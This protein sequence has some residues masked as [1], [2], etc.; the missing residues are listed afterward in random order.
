MSALPKQLR[1]EFRETFFFVA[2]EHG[3]DA[4]IE[5]VARLGEQ[6]GSGD[7][8]ASELSQLI[9]DVARECHVE[10][11]LILGR[12]QHFAASEPRQ[13]AMWVAKKRGYSFPQIGLA[14]GRSH[15]TVHHGVWRVN[16]TPLLLAEAQRCLAAIERKEQST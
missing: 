10:P 1:Q 6:L 4:A 15:A 11:A 3:L 9:D 5:A 7:R 8:V 16:N 14:L 13:V 2:A 12:M